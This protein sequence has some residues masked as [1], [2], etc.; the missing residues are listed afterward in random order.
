MGISNIEKTL[1]LYQK[2]T[3]IK[4]QLNLHE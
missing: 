3:E 2:L 4:E 1:E